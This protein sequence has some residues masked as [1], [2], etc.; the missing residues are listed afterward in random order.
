L[1]IGSAAAYGALLA[2]VQT[3]DWRGFWAGV[4]WIL[5]AGLMP[6]FWLLVRNVSPVAVS[7]DSSFEKET[8]DKSYTLMKA[9][10]SPAFWAFALATSFFNLVWSAVTLYQRE[11]LSERGFDPE[12]STYNTV[13]GTLFL[14]GLISNLI[15]GWLANRGV[16]LGRLIF[17]GLVMLGAGLFLFPAVS[18]TTHAVL[19]GLL[20]G[21]GG[22]PIVVV[23]FAIWGQAFGRLHLGKIQAAAQVLTVFASESGPWLLSQCKLLTDSYAPFFQISAAVMMV[24]GICAWLVQMPDRS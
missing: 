19:Y 2:A 22:G 16:S 5:L 17:A 18:S 4:G 1:A 10:K 15:S 14:T 13:M 24:L 20:L 21:V 7:A 6:L 12:G 8:L 23:L 9:L 3:K 11:I